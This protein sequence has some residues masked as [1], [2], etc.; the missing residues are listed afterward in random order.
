MLPKGDLFDA[1]HTPRPRYAQAAPR[2]SFND[3]A[4]HKQVLNPKTGA[5]SEPRAAR[6]SIG[7]KRAV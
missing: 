2:T 7:A 1:P 5:A 4:A 3:V 6:L